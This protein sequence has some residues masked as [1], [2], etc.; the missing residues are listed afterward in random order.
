MPEEPVGETPNPDP[1]IPP[2]ETPEGDKSVPTPH[3][4]GDENAQPA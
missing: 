1:K 4:L 2:D 3:E